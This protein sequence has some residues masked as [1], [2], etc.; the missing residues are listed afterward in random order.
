MHLD[1]DSRH[2]LADLSEVT[3]RIRQL[4]RVL[5]ARWQRPMAPEQR[6]LSQLKWRA[7]EL[8]VLRAFGRGKLHVRATSDDASAES[9]ALEYHRRIAERLGPV[10]SVRLEQSA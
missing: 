3:G 1:I 4:K 5:G 10:Y 2:F 7:T 9:E 8:C 6:E